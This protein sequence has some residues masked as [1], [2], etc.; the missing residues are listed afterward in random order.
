MVYLGYLFYTA[1]CTHGQLRLVGGNI[2]NEGR[3]EIC[4]SNIWGTVCDNFWGTT[5]AAIVCW[6]LGYLMQGRNIS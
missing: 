2:E 6:Q 5:D 4:L 3:V 1:P